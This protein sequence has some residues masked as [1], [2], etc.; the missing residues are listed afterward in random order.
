MMVLISTSS[1]HSIPQPRSTHQSYELI[2]RTDE[3]TKETGAIKMQCRD[4]FAENIPVSEVQFW[5][6]RTSPC[7]P[8]LRE[9]GDFK[10]VE[11]DKHTISFILSQH[12][13]GDYTCARRTNMRDVQKSPPKKLTCKMYN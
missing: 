5:L 11:T 9:R 4:A 10:V 13:E 6:N 8:G 2:Y 12:L 7:D 3:T 1:Q